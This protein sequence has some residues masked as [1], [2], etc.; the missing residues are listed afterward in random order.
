MTRKNGGVRVE[1]HWVSHAIKI[2]FVFTCPV[3]S[4]Y[5]Y[6]AF[7]HLSKVGIKHSKNYRDN[8]KFKMTKLTVMRS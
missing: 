4:R 1:A 2:A 6:R 3:T 7:T 5:S 8:P